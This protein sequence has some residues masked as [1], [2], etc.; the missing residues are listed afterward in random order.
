MV[1]FILKEPNSDKE[2]PIR[3]YCY[4]GGKVIIISTGFK[5]HPDNWNKPTQRIKKDPKKVKDSAKINYYLGNMSDI[6]NSVNTD[7]VGKKK[8][9]TKEE[10]KNIVDRRIAGKPDVDIPIV[11]K[12][13]ES[14]VEFTRLDE[15]KTG[16]KGNLVKA[17]KIIK[18]YDSD[19]GSLIFEGFDLTYCNGL[20]SYMTYDKLYSPNYIALIIS[21]IKKYLK[22]T[23]AAGIHNSAEFLKFKAQNI[24]VD[25]IVL[26][27]D[28]IQ[29]LELVELDEYNDRIRD[30]FLVQVN[31]GLRYVDTSRLVPECILDDNSI[32]IRTVKTNILVKLPIQPPLWNIINKYNGG[33]PKRICT[34]L[35]D[36]KIKEIARLAG[37]TKL[38]IRTKKRGNKLIQETLPLY[39]LIS[40]HTGRRTALTNLYL[41]GMSLMDIKNVSGHTTITQLER[42]IKVTQLDSF[43]RMKDHP[44]FTGKKTIKKDLEV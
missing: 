43:K 17:V 14:L 34:A 40:S 41:R 1:K 10:F 13:M 8:E 11:P 7:F 9:F 44:A 15:E 24:E 27:D 23:M 20:I 29:K 31:T 32:T 3:M 22:L 33:F 16:V 37:L 28:Q 26:T 12:F 42:Y 19:W 5:V 25:S 36:T 2:T 4:F 38:T 39:K 21:Q 30:F 6:A 35:L 18:D